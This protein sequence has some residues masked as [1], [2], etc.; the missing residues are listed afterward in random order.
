MKI[1][2]DCN[3]LLPL[4]E[5]FK[6]SH[7][8]DGR[9][10]SCKLCFKIKVNPEGR[11]KAVRKYRE[12]EENKIKIRE[13]GKSYRAKNREQ[14][15]QRVKDWHRINKH[16]SSFY[17]AKRRAIKRK[18]TPW[19]SQHE[20]IKELYK[21]AR[22]L[23]EFTGVQFH[24]DHIVPLVNPKVQGLHV[25]ANL[26]IIPYYENLSKNNKLIEDIV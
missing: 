25:L 13:Y 3:N 15:L 2:K 9:L 19:W 18:A 11:I 1:C 20:E 12:N 10:N 5:F 17:K 23:T 7:M 16:L 14:C 26:R 21:E 4:S 6:N 22:R 8:V 24:V